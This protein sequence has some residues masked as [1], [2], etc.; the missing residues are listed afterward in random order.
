MM[1]A[2]PQVK[3]GTR[4]NVG[5]IVL[6]LVCLCPDQC[7]FCRS[8]DCSRMAHNAQ[9][10]LQEEK[11]AFEKEK[12]LEEWG[13]QGLKKKLQVKEDL[14]VEERR[15]WHVAC[16]NE[17]KKIF[18]VRTKITN[19]EA[20]VEGLKKSEVYFKAKYEEA[21]SNRERVEF[22]LASTLSV[23]I[24]KAEKQ[25]TDSL[26]VDLAV[27][28]VKAESAEE[29]RKVSLAALNLAQENYVEVQSTVEPLLTDPEWMQNYGVAHIANSILNATELDK[30]VVALTMAT[31]SACYH[32][33]Y[34]EC[35]K[36]VEE[37]LHQ[38]FGSRRCSA[39]KMAEDE[40]C[41][42]EENYNSLSISDARVV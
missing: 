32:A 19:L 2:F 6:S 5:M 13:L 10:K 7:C 9:V 20:Q 39:G 25:K 28:K 35:A 40:L 15:N 17:N 31:R 1:G 4:K 38:H 16:D 21:K 3:C 29:A 24:S 34:L 26:E 22:L 14:R 37:A 8:S 18:A 27:E 12:K 11:A 30:A 33:G 42:A 23:F 36:H 41:R